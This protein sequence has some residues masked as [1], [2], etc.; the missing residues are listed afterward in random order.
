[1]EVLIIMYIYFIYTHIYN[2]YIILYV[3]IFCL[4]TR[5][6]YFPLRWEIWGV[7]CQG[8]RIWRILQ[9]LTSVLLPAPCLCSPLALASHPPL[10]VPPGEFCSPAACSIW[11]EMLGAR[12][13]SLSGILIDW[14]AQDTR[15]PGCC[16]WRPALACDLNQ[17]PASRSPEWR[18]SWV[19]E[20]ASLVPHR[21]LVLFALFPLVTTA[22]RGVTKEIAENRPGWDAGPWAA[23]DSH[24]GQRPRPR[25]RPPPTQELEFEGLLWE[26]K[27][28]LA[29]TYSLV[30]RASLRRRICRLGSCCWICWLFWALGVYLCCKKTPGFS[31]GAEEIGGWAI[32]LSRGWK[33]VRW[34]C[35][36]PQRPRTA[37]RRR[38]RSQAPRPRFLLWTSL[39]SAR[40]SDSMGTST[41]SFEKEQCLLT[42]SSDEELAPFVHASA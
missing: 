26:F 42:A 28:E 32:L 15:A 18:A 21:W 37:A 38:V 16:F 5:T 41:P 1:M 2:T 7:E 25:P 13:F 6:L 9:P 33:A 30:L 11:A 22:P 8:K 14:G 39:S 17:E 40:L 31:Q 3:F 12:R 20:A 24:W 35:W 23:A 29:H 34:G 10:R 19:E 36:S 27:P 4:S